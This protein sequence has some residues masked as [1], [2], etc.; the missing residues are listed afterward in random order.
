MFPKNRKGQELSAFYEGVERPDRLV[1]VVPGLGGN[2]DEPHLKV[3]REA[4]LENGF[5]VLSF[6]PYNTGKSGG[7]YSDITVS[8]YISDL[9]DVI[10][11]A[12]T[13]TWFREPFWLAGHSLGGLTVGA[14]AE[15]NNE[16]ISGLVLLSSVISGELSCETE[17]YRNK[18]EDW[19]KTGWIINDVGERMPWGHMTD[20]LKYNLVS[21]AYKLSMPVLL[22]VGN[23]DK[24]TP[25]E[26][27]SLLYS[28]IASRDKKL[29]IILGADHIFDGVLGELKGRLNQGIE[30]ICLK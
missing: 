10:E 4:F 21:D 9:E 15:K 3:A 25:P 11:W 16:K 8:G 26:H 14:Y 19:K 1:F 29:D 18:V 12:R 5:G 17:I 24:N 6:D 2:F 30:T 23:E 28:V 22:V 27:Q 13:Q 7:K 20:R